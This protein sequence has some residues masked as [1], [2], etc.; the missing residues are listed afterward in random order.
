MS[1]FVGNVSRNVSEKDLEKAQASGNERKARLRYSRGGCAGRSGRA[2]RA[3]SSSA[4]AIAFASSFD[5][6]GFVHVRRFAGT[7]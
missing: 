2:A 3:S 6:I 1:L 5:N 4:S 7:D